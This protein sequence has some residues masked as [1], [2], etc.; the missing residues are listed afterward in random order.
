MV[1]PTALTSA[2]GLEGMKLESKRGR[3]KIA[4]DCITDM[5]NTTCE[6]LSEHLNENL[7]ENLNEKWNEKK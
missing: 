6:N 4:M 1:F 7:S 5:I 3:A 2:Y